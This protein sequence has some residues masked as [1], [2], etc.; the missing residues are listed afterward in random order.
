MGPTTPC[1]KIRDATMLVPLVIVYVA[2]EHDDSWYYFLLILL[3]HL[4][5]HV[6]GSAYRV[7]ATILFFIRRARVWRMMEHNKH[8]FDIGRNRVQLPPKPLPLSA[9]GLVA[10]AVQ[11]QEQRVRGAY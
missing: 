9:G 2:G 8:E 5:Q 6:L 10:R 1:D 7:S 11:N 4:R 3:Q